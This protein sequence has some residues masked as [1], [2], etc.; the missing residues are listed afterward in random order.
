MYAVILQ[1]FYFI[2]LCLNISGE[3]YC[4]LYILG[5]VGWYLYTKWPINLMNTILGRQSI[6]LELVHML[7]FS[8]NYEAK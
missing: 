8:L 4:P 2:L 3:S 1:L 5:D 7:A 6:L